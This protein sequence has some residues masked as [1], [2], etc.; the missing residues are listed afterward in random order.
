MADQNP[1]PAPAAKPKESI[2][3]EVKTRFYRVLSLLRHNGKHYAKDSKVSLTDQEAKVLLDR[4]VV[5]PI[6]PGAAKE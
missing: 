6:A 3:A 4:K 5:A 2:A 1:A